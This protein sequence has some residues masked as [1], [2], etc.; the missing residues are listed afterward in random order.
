MAII[1]KS[2][3]DGYTQVSLGELQFQ[4]MDLEGKIGI[5]HSAT[6]PNSGDTPDFVSIGNLE[7]QYS[8]GTTACY[9]KVLS[10]GSLD[11]AVQDIS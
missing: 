2:T 3:A 6:P 8:L 1:T 10:E 9:I 11:I 7:I 5:I 4:I